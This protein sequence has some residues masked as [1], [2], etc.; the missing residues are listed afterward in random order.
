MAPHQLRQLSKISMRL[1]DD[2][3][4]AVR[5]GTEIR[6][7]LEESN[8]PVSSDSWLAR[9][10]LPTSAEILDIPEPDDDSAAGDVVL[11]INKTSGRWRTKAAYLSAHYDLLREDAVKPLRDA[12]GRM[13]VKPFA[14]EEEYGSSIGIYE[15]VHITALTFSTRGIAVRVVF[16]LARSGKRVHWEQSKRLIT[17]SLVVLT[18]AD[19]LFETKCIVAVVAARPLVGLEQNP[20]E[21]DLFF[22]RAEDLEI[23]PAKEWIMVEDRTAYYEAHRHTLL[24]LQKLMREPFPLKEHLV[25]AQSAVEP[26]AYVQMKPKTDLSCIFDPTSTET[27]E[28]I[29]ILNAW[30]EKPESSELDNT[31]LSALQRIMTKR[32][33]VVQGPPGTGKTY[34]SIVAL[35]AS[36][37]NMA[38]GDP[39]I[40]ITSQ[41]NHALDQLLRQVAEFEPDFIRL[42]GRSKDQDVVKKRTLFEVRQMSQKLRVF[43]GL[44][45]PA[46]KQM[47]MLEKVMRIL[48]TP[49]ELG[50]SALDHVLLRKLKLLTEEQCKSLERSREDWVQHGQDTAG[51]SPME[52]WMGQALVPVQRY[53]Q[54]EDFGFEYEELDLEF[55]QLKEMEAENFAKD[56]EDFETLR[57]TVVNIADNYTGKKTAGLD[58]QQ[59]KKLLENQDLR[60]IP[61][62]SRGAVYYYLQEQAKK[63]LLTVFR[64]EAKKFNDATK[65]IGMTTTG[66]SKYRAL[67]ASLRPKIV[68]IEEAA[69]TLEAPVIATCVPTLEHLILVG[70]HQQLRPH[71]HVRDLE[72]PPYNLNMS[73]FERMI[74]NKIEF[75][76]LRRQRRMIPE[77]RRILKPIYGDLIT[78]HP[79]MKDP[80]VRP[81]IPGMGSISSYF[82]THEWPETRDQYMSSCNP[83]EAEMIVNFFDYLVLNGVSY[84]QITVLT[85][86]NGQRKAILKGLRDH[87]NLKGHI[88]KVVTV[89]SYQGEENDIVLLSLVRS[90]DAGKVGFLNVD[91]RVCVALSRAKRGFY[92]FGN[93]ELLVNASQTWVSVIEIMAGKKK[94]FPTLG[95]K[96]RLGFHLPLEC[97]QHGRKTFIKEPNDWANI[98]GGCEMKCKTTL[99]CGHPCPLNC[100]PSQQGTL[101]QDSNSG[102]DLKAWDRYASGGVAEDD[103]ALE[104]RAATRQAQQ[105][106]LERA[107]RVSNHQLL[108]KT[109]IL[110]ESLSPTKVAT[111]SAS[112][113][114]ATSMLT[115]LPPVAQ[116]GNFGPT[117][118]VNNTATT[119]GTT[120]S[121]SAA[122]TAVLVDVPVNTQHH[123]ES[124][125]QPAKAATTTYTALAETPAAA[126][127]AP[128]A[129]ASSML[130][131][132]PFED[133]GI[134]VQSQTTA[135]N[136]VVATNTQA[137]DPQVSLLD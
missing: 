23:D 20:P 122:T 69:E 108:P 109:L 4:Q 67:V 9:P 68:L 128:Q 71:C 126:S 15:N 54:P 28:N 99:K 80:R 115:D 112:S 104:R 73:L 105:I 51:F 84:D 47:Q 110:D 106:A 33:A 65:V 53:V 50:N 88:F 82:Y 125:L 38:P 120:A 119:K 95:P 76:T 32:L 121:G 49:L 59:V 70:D 103:A 43:G 11:E 3:S 5:C 97:T 116:G 26:P 30:P 64:V 48:L 18:P 135:A 79:A 94:P 58:E 17:G 98:D 75:N 1:K 36:L 46:R 127:S 45:E 133:H 83:G 72:G 25:D 111:F 40:I 42:G 14:K 90:N 44:R 37:H 136:A 10:E 8:Q 39:P 34:V 77:I 93:G 124:P 113:N 100:H 137:L 7:Y 107:R 41:T 74:N 78:D 56:D 60:K 96:R 21:I 81:P 114:F 102:S 130:I 66:F 31:Q 12:V 61:P 131:D 55:E 91:N 86:Y 16:S 101:T 117:L 85:F 19:D 118:P 2:Y 63:A 52:V 22:A 57:G 27:F 123:L 35:K 62:R 132:I 13:R 87:P 29:D 134:T 89:D 129:V 92:I 6:Q 24:A